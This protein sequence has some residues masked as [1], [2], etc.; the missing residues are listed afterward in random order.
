MS[1]TTSAP[2]RERVPVEH[3]L[4]GLDRRS[5]P[6]ALTVVGVFVVLTVVVPR[7]DDAVD[8]DDP[9]RAG[10]R[11]ALTDSIAV[12]PPTGW[13]VEQGFR[14]APDGRVD[15][16]G[17]ASLSGD[18]VVVTLVPGDFDGTPAQLLA[19]V[20]KVTSSTRDPSFR[21]SGE[22]VTVTT[23][24]GGTGVLQTYSSVRGDGVAAA[25][26]L[27]GTGVEV[28]AHGPPA[29]LRA[30]GTEIADMIASIDDGNGP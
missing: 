24:A 15:G 8:W 14:V 4:L 7:I 28:T 29:Q 18:G 2:G 25:F 26:V 20:E 27:D 16:S 17:Q 30:A 12:T 13:D 9:V 23:N 11:L 21:V 5:F 19:Q 10:D 1:S 22:P 3:R 6:Y